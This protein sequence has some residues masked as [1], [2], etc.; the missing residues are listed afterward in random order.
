MTLIDL[1]ER[2]HVPDTLLRAAVRKISA[3]RLVEESA[4]DP[5]LFNARKRELIS[6]WSA[7][8]IA[9]ETQAANEQHYEV[10]PAFFV[11][12]LGTHLKYSCGYWPDPDTNLDESEA[13]MLKLSCERAQLEDGMQILELG[14]GWGSLTLWMARHYPKAQILAVS[15]SNLQ[16][17][18]IEQRAAAEGIKNIRVQ[19]CDINNFDP[20]EKFDR[21]VSIEM[22][23]HLRN[24]KLL[25]ER[26]AGWL[27]A[28]GK[29]FSHVFCHRELL[30]PYEDRGDDDWMS[31]YFF[32]G[33]IMP[34]F[35]YFLL[36][37]RSLHC[38]NRWWV[39]GQHYE[40][41]SNAWLAR[42]DANR[43]QILAVL[44]EHYSDADARL[45]L[46]R[47]RMFYIAVAEFFGLQ[48]G[49][50]WGVGH[51]LMSPR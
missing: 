6:Q 36:C 8:P 25:F 32:T 40:A 12:T 44:G 19:T 23:E 3:R 35:D 15:N 51:Y 11:H 41:T 27:K 46:Q 47:W 31:R 50:Q 39:N 9:I 26:I 18:Y 10:P 4:H 37:Q 1:C 20:Q 29:L 13:A 5:A 30:Y 28:D 49:R 7:G 33:G 22:M 38:E 21:V 34:S 16:R 14:C 17:G 2:G 48:Q 43:E 42:T 45:W 24:H